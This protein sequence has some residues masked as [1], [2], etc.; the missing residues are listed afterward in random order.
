MKSIYIRSLCLL[1]TV[2]F[3]IPSC[4]RNPLDVDISGVNI[5]PVKIFRFDK[6]FFAVTEGDIPSNLAALR[7]KYPGFADLYIHNLICPGG[8]QDSACIPDITRFIKDKDMSG[9]FADCQKVFGEDALSELEGQ[10]S[11]L[12]RHYRYYFPGKPL[13]GIYTMMSGFNYAIASADSSF[14]IG[15]E[16]YLGKNCR[17]YDMLRVPDYKRSAMQKEFIPADLV[18]AWMTKVFPNQNH[19]GTLLS[20]MIYQGKL[21]YL[22]DALLPQTP[23]TLKIGFSSVQMKWCEEHE[24]D[25]WGHLIQNKFLYS[26]DVSIVTK[27]TGEGPFTAGFVKESPARTGVWLGWKIVR[28]YMRAYPKTTLEEL[29]AMEDPQIILSKSGYKP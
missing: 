23:D 10:F 7:K 14:A 29:M 15:L 6:D 22:A 27:F 8:T 3:L 12:F 18:R 28:A 24:K 1:A 5:P 26:N 13:P 4:G 17:F 9:A 19:S 2:F 16:M 20:T 21:L 25:M 11:D